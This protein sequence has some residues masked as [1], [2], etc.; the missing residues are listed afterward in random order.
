MTWLYI[1]P[2]ALS[3]ESPPSALAEG[4]STSAST[5]PFTQMSEP[6]LLSRGKPMPLPA[7]SR[8]WK[9]DV[10]LRRLSGLTCEPS[11]AARGVAQW[12]SWWVGTPASPSPLQASDA[13]LTTPD[14]S[15]LTCSESSKSAA[16]GGSSSRTWG[17]I[18]DG[19]STRSPE[20]WIAQVSE[21]R[22]FWR[23][24][25]T[26]ARRTNANDFFVS[27]SV[28]P[29]ATTSDSRSSWP[30]PTVIIANQEFTWQG[31]MRE[32]ARRSNSNLVIEAAVATAEVLVPETWM[33]PMLDGAP[34]YPTPTAS[35]FG[36]SQNAGSVP[37]ERRTKGTPSLTT[38][39]SRGQLP[40]LRDQPTSP[41][42]AST[43]TPS[44]SRRL[45]LNVAFVEMLM[46]WPAGWTLPWESTT[47]R[48]LQQELHVD[49]LRLLGNGVVPQQAAFAFRHLVRAHVRAHELFL[50]DVADT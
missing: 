33:A 43:S 16:P 3:S 39:A 15:G 6:S 31:A 44:P 30:T 5:S 45:R 19:A 22:S 42:G 46:G 26:S 48:E 10:W 2:I 36:S 7:L 32:R 34:A 49:R 20:T 37:H 23:K 4:G 17:V 41:D 12:I 29:T 50:S 35:V 14:T 11:T 9:K 24:L 18:C 40:S 1:P 8:G 38:A 28:Q 13:A 25:R 21:W 27:P 47:T